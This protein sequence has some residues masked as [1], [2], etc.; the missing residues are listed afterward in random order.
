MLD[1]V[2]AEESSERFRAAV[3]ARALGQPG[4]LDELRRA[5]H[6]L[7]AEARSRGA[8]AE[9]MIVQLKG[10]WDSA[11]GQRDA[12]LVPERVPERVPELARARETAVTAAIKGYYAA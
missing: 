3:V 6:E 9:Q 12:N 10:L 2:I 11:A 1:A 4:S 8:S 7:G 5:A